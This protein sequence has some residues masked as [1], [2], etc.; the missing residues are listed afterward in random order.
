MPFGIALVL[1]A[2]CAGR[3]ASKTRVNALV[4]RASI[5]KRHSFKLMDCRVKPGNDPDGSAPTALARCDSSEHR[6]WCA[7]LA[8]GLQAH[9]H[10]RQQRRHDVERVSALGGGGERDGGLV[11]DD[12]R[13]AEDE[14]HAPAA[15]PGERWFH[16]PSQF[17]AASRRGEQ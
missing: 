12:E 10:S 17:S 11:V 3:S 5:G 13:N 9:G 8:I 15:A 1:Y 6:L 4:T 2:S 7:P 14:A 16:V